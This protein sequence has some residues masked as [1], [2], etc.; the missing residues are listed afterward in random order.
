M[1]SYTH[2]NI[3]SYIPPYLLPIYS[4]IYIY[5]YNDL[6]VTFEHLIYELSKL[7]N[8]N[9]SVIV[10]DKKNQNKPCLN[11]VILNIKKNNIMYRKLF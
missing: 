9:I 1:R 7:F 4:Y 8:N 5:G 2:P 10:N 3:S 11:M 6:N